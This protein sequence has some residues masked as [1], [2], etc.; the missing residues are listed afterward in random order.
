MIK[1]RN[2]RT[3]VRAHKLDK[4]NFKKHIHIVEGYN[5]LDNKKGGIFHEGKYE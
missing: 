2:K 4:A 1:T 3:G 5:F